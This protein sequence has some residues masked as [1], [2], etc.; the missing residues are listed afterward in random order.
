MIPYGRQ[1]IDLSDVWSVVKALK[2]DL[3]T[4]GPMVKNFEKALEFVT[5]AK[6]FAVSSGTAA[7]HC[8]YAGIGITSKDEIISPANTF[9]ATQS[10]ALNLGAKVVFADID[11][12]T[13]LISPNSVEKLI[14]PRTK[15]IV[16][17]D[18]AGQPCDIDLFRRLVADRE[19]YLIE[20]ASHSLGSRYNGQ[21]VGSL[22]DV[23]TFSFY[24]TKNITTGEGGAVSSI[25]SEIF[26]KA[27]SFANHG[28]ERDP[29]KFSG[30][31]I[32]PWVYEIQNLGLN[33]RL[34]DLNCALGI[35]QLKKINKFKSRRSE[36]FR[37]YQ[38][39]F[40]LE[41]RIQTLKVEDYADSM[42]HLFPILV[43]PNLRD[44]LIAYLHSNL[45]GV[46]VNYIPSIMHPIFKKLGY[47]YKELPNT[48]N[49]YLR[50]VSLP[51]HVGL[52]ISEVDYISELILDFIKS[53]G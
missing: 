10:T 2:S 46:Q 4:T 29:N 47:D 7:L 45:I 27:K 5:G 32:G 23:T 31:Q 36:I 3:I 33:Y 8:A 14:T 20:D 22:A 50:E 44:Q 21:T 39:N 37:R 35:S 19:I 6:T 43:P 42:W 1:Y 24:P 26:Q 15:A 41:K 13:G 9:I 53:E 51:I 12:D 30:D 16:L 48:I 18:Y 28:A 52:R 17:V 34:S 40:S 25:R 49:F 11:P 38:Q